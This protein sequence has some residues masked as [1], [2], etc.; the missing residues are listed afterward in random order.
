MGTRPD[1]SL[2]RLGIRLIIY[3][4]VPLIPHNKLLSFHRERGEARF[5]G[6]K[7]DGTNTTAIN[8]GGGQDQP[9]ISD[10][11]P[12]AEIWGSRS[13]LGLGWS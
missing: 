7:R 1:T 2:T 9:D 4:L 6:G 8:R 3:D 5:G 10:P 11:G 12:A 13:G